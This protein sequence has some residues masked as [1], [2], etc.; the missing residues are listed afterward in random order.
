MTEIVLHGAQIRAP[1]GKVVAARVAQHVRADLLPYDEFRETRF[2]MEWARP[3]G[4]VDFVGVALDKS[5]TG[6]AMFGVFRHERDGPVDNQTRK[7]MRSI[8]P[9][10]RRALLIGRM[11]DLKSAKAATFEGVLDAVSVSMFLLDDTGRMVHANTAGR[12][13]LAQGCVVRLAYGK[14]TAINASA[15]QAL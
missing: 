5:A 8:V 12:A 14:L 7:R 13:M 15:T 4:L 9:H 6:V 11:I 3:Q 10:I 2:N 1:V